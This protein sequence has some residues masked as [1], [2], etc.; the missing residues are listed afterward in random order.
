MQSAVGTRRVSNR[1]K[2]LVRPICQCDAHDLAHQTMR[3][4]PDDQR[5]VI[6]VAV[7]EDTPGP[8]GDGDAH[9][10]GDAEGF[11]PARCMRRLPAADPGR[12]YHTRFWP[13]A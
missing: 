13:G 7:R 8:F 3:L 4:A 10:Q 6:T 9:G 2:R 12:D 11:F 5:T 1:I